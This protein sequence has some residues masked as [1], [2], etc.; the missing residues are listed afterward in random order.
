MERAVAVGRRA[1]EII[2]KKKKGRLNWN[3]IKSIGVAVE[4]IS[5]DYN[6]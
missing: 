2:I 5:L 4:E 1:H 3:G 6:N